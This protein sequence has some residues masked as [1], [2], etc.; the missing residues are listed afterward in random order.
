MT[1]MPPIDLTAA[2]ESHKTTVLSD[3]D[4]DKLHA[5]DVSACAFDLYERL[6]GAR[7]M[8]KGNSTFSMF[9]RG[10]AYEAR[11][12]SAVQAYCDKNG[13]WL[14]KPDQEIEYEGI[15]GHP[16]MLV[17][18]GEDLL[19][20]VDITTTASKYTEWKWGHVLK[21]A[22]Y[23]RALGT[24]LFCDWVFSIGF[25]G[26]ILS[27]QA[28]WFSLDD[29]FGGITWD[30]RLDLA[31]DY[32]HEIAAAKVPPAKVPPLD[33]ATGE[34][35]DWRCKKSYCD[36]ICPLNAKLKPMSGAA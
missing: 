1:N 23:A 6:R 28:H 5:S 9:E 30:Q 8:P 25:G 34:P 3:R 24:P 20:V 12:Y 15:V 32:V 22:W 10:H 16:D 13:L 19:A 11:I 31:I 21:S 4:P 33:P 7:R 14:A 36:A 17:Y 29:S 27:E 18:R 26:N 2:W 35:E